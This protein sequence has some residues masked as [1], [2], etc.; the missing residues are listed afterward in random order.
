MATP[1]PAGFSSEQQWSAMRSLLAQA[2][3]TDTD[4]LR[5]IG[6]RS[7][8]GLSRLSG[9]DLARATADDSV[10]SILIRL[11]LLGRIVS[12]QDAAIALRPID[13]DAWIDA[14]L[15]GATDHE[16]TSRIQLL[17][18]M[19]V[20]IATDPPPR[21]G[22]GTEPPEDWVMGIGGSTQT[23][24]ALTVRRDVGRM[25]DVGTGC[26][27]HALLAARH[28]GAVVATDINPRALA[29]TRL[30][31][32]LNGFDNIE[33]AVGSFF[34]PVVDDRFDL[35][36]SNPPFVIS[37]ERS[38]V[39]RD[40]GMERD[41]AVELVIRGCAKHLSPGGMAFVLCNWVQPEGED[42]TGR[43]RSWLEGS[44]CDAWVCEVGRLEPELYARQWIGH[45]ARDSGQALERRVAR[46]VGAFREQGIAAV[47][48]GHIVLRRRESDT[49]WFYA[50]PG[51]FPETFAGVVGDRIV[52]LFDALTFLQSA[53]DEQIL[54]TP[55]AVPPDARIMREFA[56][57]QDGWEATET[58]IVRSEGLLREG[59]L[60]DAT[61]HLLMALRPGSPP[62]EAIAHL[63]AHSGADPAQITAPAVGV[64]RKLIERG[65]LIARPAG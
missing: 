25:L 21:T 47:S 35:I 38:F 17:P 49:P 52:S 50:P 60:D 4:I 7:I 5:Q 41:G 55:L 8:A 31:A 58:R 1:T 20:L 62:R 15:L 46:W 28:S 22:P 36:V 27:V 14:G 33:T 51:P 23:L 63:A 57:G 37:P 42:A 39:Y 29:F 34:E 10:R 61:V 18:F 59:R 45:T 40:A 48:S 19:G 64:V 26:G 43:L 6:S 54:D 9:E 2:G 3:Y 13:L 65:F 30:N 44:G 11:F 53:T 56:P 12:A 24:A 32:R 16:V